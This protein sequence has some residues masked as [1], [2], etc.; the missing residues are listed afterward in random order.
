MSRLLERLPHPSVRPSG[1]EEVAGIA[2]FLA[3][4]VGW[5]LWLAVPD[6]DWDAS[7]GL[8]N[9]F[10]LGGLIAA[11]PSALSVVV[12]GYLISRAV[13]AVW[14]GWIPG[15]LMMGVGFL[16]VDSLGELIFVGGLLLMLGWP[17]YFLPLIGVGVVLR[18][19][20]VKRLAS[21]RP[22]NRRLFLGVGASVVVAGVL[23]AT[24]YATTRDSSEPTIAAPRATGPLCKSSGVRY[25]GATAEGAEVCFTLSPDRSEWIEIGVSF[26]SASGCPDA[27]TGTRR[28]GGPLPFTAPGRFA[29]DG[30]TATVRGEQASGE[31]SDP[32]ICGSKTFEWDA[33]RIP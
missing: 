8:T 11:I 6:W 20:H 2:L 19:R 3:V 13:A 27:A 33:R 22:V 23:A 14:L 30:F 29:T 24:L 10:D 28:T 15:A 25:A 31:L 1:R 16:F 9:P 21:P 26:V 18:A 32:D 7:A 4:T 17:L 5:T 12:T